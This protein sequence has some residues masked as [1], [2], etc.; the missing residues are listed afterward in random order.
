MKLDWSKVGIVSELMAKHEMA[1]INSE[2]NNKSTPH[3]KGSYCYYCK[4]PIIINAEEYSL[5]EECI[6]SLKENCGLKNDE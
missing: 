1:R 5:C 3:E 2:A 4:K 6:K